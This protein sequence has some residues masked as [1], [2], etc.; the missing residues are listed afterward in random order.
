MIIL[1][2]NI[3]AALMADGAEINP[4]LATVPRYELYTTVVARCC[5]HTV[6]AVIRWQS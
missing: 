6:L 3:V 1:H 5:H 4:W 2:T